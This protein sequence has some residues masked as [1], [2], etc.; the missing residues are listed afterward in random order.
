MKTLE[1]ELAEALVGGRIEAAHA[2]PETGLVAIT[3]Y[4]GGKRTLGVGIGPRVVGLGWLPRLPSARAPASHPLVAAMRSHLVDRRVRSVMVDEEGRVWISVGGEVPLAQLGLR[5]G[6][7][8][9]VR[10]LGSTGEQV[11]RW[12]RAST[13]G[14]AQ[15]PL[16]VSREED[17]AAAGAALFESNERAAWTEARAALLRALDRRNKA[18]VRRADA[19]RG[20]LARLSEV[21]RLQRI[22]RL[23]LAQGH[24][25]PRGATR[26]TLEDWEQGGMIEVALDPARPAKAQAETF[27]A[28]ARRYQ[29]GA[30]V[31]NRR[32]EETERLRAAVEALASEVAKVPE[33]LAALE[34][35]LA[36]ARA[37]GAL[38]GEGRE[39]GTDAAARGRGARLPYVLYRGA[40]GRAILVGRGGK[41]N[42]ALT[43]RYAR[44]HDLWLHAKDIKGAH[45]VVPLEKGQSCPPELLVDAATLAAYHSDA[46]DE[47]IVDVSYVE[48]RY[49]R[50]PRGSAPGAVVYERE[51]VMPLRMERER[52]ERLLAS[53]EQM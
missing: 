26:A 7:R 44:P 18:L 4:A 13:E 12:P 28:K 31:M 27:F 46:R 48:R 42:D 41:D 11:V 24:K 38:S 40:F 21:E 19:V 32:L 8:G 37:L 9:E 29:R 25:I 10:V 30:A 43:T 47:L 34:P 3:V 2:T 23:L 22:G 33:D 45:V 1:A 52:I 16:R 17:L 14:G 15:D 50:K 49:V 39:A 6:R 20:D 36:R 5:P 35:L 51:K 53:R